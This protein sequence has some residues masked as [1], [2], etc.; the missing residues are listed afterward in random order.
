MSPSLRLTSV[1][2]KVADLK[3]SIDFYTRQFGLAAIREDASEAELSTS[4]AGTPLLTLTADPRGTPQPQDAAG[5]FHVA[6][7]LPDRAAL[8]RWLQHAVRQGVR[9]EGFSD[10]G[11][12]EALYLSDPEGNGIEVYVDR[13]REEWPFRDGKLAMTTQPLDLDSLLA[14]GAGPAVPPASALTTAGACWGHLHLRVTDLDRSEAFYRKALG[15]SLTQG[16]FPGARFL[17]ADNYHHHLGL[18]NWGNPRRGRA[19]NTLGLASATFARNGVRKSE[20]VRDPDG[21]EIRIAP[22]EATSRT[23]P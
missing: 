8:A 19:L 6:L 13:P 21:I 4:S 23:Q 20:I 17:A 10:H 7:L 1:H 12:S 22:L 5:L 9:F 11:V 14:T 3:Q 2:L 18:N 15:L 16:D